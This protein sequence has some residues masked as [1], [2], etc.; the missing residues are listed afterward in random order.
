MIAPIKYNNLVT[1]LLF[2]MLWKVHFGGTSSQTM[3]D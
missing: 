2:F 3:L 1:F